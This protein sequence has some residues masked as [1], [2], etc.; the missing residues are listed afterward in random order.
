M[1]RVMNTD[2][3]DQS[4]SYEEFENITIK[5]LVSQI[6][7]PTGTRKAQLCFTVGHASSPPKNSRMVVAEIGSG[8]YAIGGYCPK[9]QEELGLSD[10]DSASFSTDAD[11]NLK[12]VT[13][14][15]A[16][17]SVETSNDS[18]KVVFTAAGVME[19]GDAGQPAALSETIDSYF[20]VLDQM[21]T[22]LDS[23]A[24][25]IYTT[26]MNENGLVPGAIPTVASKNLKADIEP[27][28]PV[29]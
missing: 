1:T 21:M 25:G 26:K 27:P 10:G 14:W 20:I 24:G 22:A 7:G 18:D 12:V 3:T 15:K 6:N 28:I 13:K 5:T 2:R 23:F 29:P 17:G 11:G 9:V 16:D 4:N 8:L 19:V